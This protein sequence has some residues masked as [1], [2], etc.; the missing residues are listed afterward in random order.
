M[1]LYQTDILQSIQM[2]TDFISYL[3]YEMYEC[4]FK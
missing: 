3:C 4:F 2:T 1:H